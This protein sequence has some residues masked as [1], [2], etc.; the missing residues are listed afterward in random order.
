MLHL[1]IAQ[2]LPQPAPTPSTD[3]TTSST[4]ISARSWPSRSLRFSSCGSSLAVDGIGANA[5]VMPKSGGPL[6]SEGKFG[7]CWRTIASG[8]RG[9]SARSAVTTFEHPRSGAR[10]AGRGSAVPQALGAPGASP[11]RKGPATF[12][13]ASCSSE[14]HARRRIDL[15]L[16][17]VGLEPTTLGSEDRC[18]IQLSYECQTLTAFLPS[19]FSRF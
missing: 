5:R 2:T 19:R 13:A 18:S 3:S 4:A 9:G 7:R 16:H 8:K 6:T 14:G 10:S 11:G 1:L 17:S 12:G 15:H